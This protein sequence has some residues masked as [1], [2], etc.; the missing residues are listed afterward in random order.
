MHRQVTLRIAGS[1]HVY[2]LIYLLRFLALA[3]CILVLDK[4]ER[5]RRNVSVVFTKP[6]VPYSQGI[7]VDLCNIPD[8]Y[9]SLDAI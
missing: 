5:T 1:L 3:L 2:S 9:A 6:Y 8:D 7:S 4:N